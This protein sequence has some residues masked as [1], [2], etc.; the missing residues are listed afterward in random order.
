MKF[1]FPAQITIAEVPA[2]F[3]ICYDDEGN[4]LEA[5]THIRDAIVGLDKT[6]S[7]LRAEADRNKKNGNETI[8]AVNTLLS[9]VGVDTVEAL[10]EHI[11][12]LNE[13]ITAKGKINPD[14]I[15]AE[16]EEGYKKQI[17]DLNTQLTTQGSLM[18]ETVLGRDVAE[19]VAK[20]GGN[21]SLLNPFV[22]TRL[23]MVEENGKMEIRVLDQDGD[24]VGDGKG[25]WQSVD[26]FVGGLKDNPDFHGAFAAR[27]PGPGGGGT[28][29][30]G[31]QQPQRHGQP[32][33]GG[34]QK[35]EK[36]PTQKITDGL[37]A[38]GMGVPQRVAGAAT[39]PGM[40]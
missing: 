10:G 19:A 1:T 33:P 8:T 28:P 26:A 36:T 27:Q 38:R 12:T 3:R 22:R 15:R 17:T 31:Q 37:R 40:D 24:Y 2:E 9:E 14:K 23:T 39:P 29:P 5:A 20:H 25:G 6:V 21:S 7:N 16:V 18:K 34:P 13:T 11:V 35:V 4:F 32:L 30:N